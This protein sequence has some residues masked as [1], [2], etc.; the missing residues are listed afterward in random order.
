[1]LSSMTRYCPTL[2]VDFFCRRTKFRLRAVLAVSSLTNR[3]SRHGGKKAI[4]H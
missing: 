2:E 3:L 4:W 1:V